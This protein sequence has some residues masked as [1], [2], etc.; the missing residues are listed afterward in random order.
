MGRAE[1]DRVTAAI[2]ALV[3]VHPAGVTIHQM[4]EAA[5]CNKT[6]NAGWLLV[7]AAQRAGLRPAIVRSAG[8][9]LKVWRAAVPA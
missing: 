6:L 3:A 8:K 4:R 2:A 1:L 5:G 9:V 7:R